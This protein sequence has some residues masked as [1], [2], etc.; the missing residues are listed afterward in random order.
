MIAKFFEIKNY[1]NTSRIYLFH[2]QNNGLKDEVIQKEFKSVENEKKVHHYHEKEILENKDF[3]YNNIMSGSFFETK[4]IIIIKNISDKFINI[5]NDIRDRNLS[6]VEIILVA[7]VLDKKSKIRNL[8]DKDKSLISIAFYQDN[9]ETLLRIIKN[10]FILLKISISHETMNRIINKTSGDRRH[11]MN[12]LDKIKSYVIDKSKITSNE[13]DTLLNL[14]GE[15]D[16][17]NLIDNCLA[18]NNKK[19]LDLLNEN[20]FTLEDS[21]AIIRTLLFK[22]KRLL[23]LSKINLVENNIEKTISMFKPPI[24]WK[25]KEI[26][27]KQ[28]KNWT[29]NQIENLI[30]DINKTEILVKK[31]SEKSIYILSDFIISKSKNINNNF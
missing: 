26:V 30:E 24:F 18:G 27:K 9:N 29:K 31:N 12:E 21:I 16:Y 17:N 25:E 3:F 6:D 1:K 15:S 11:L 4:K 8:F 19:T 20:N 28:I 13:I 23:A 10:F 7:N 22:S 14:S 5:I 2:G